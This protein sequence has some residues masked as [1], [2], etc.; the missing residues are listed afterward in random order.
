MADIDFDALLADS[1]TEIGR[2]PA[3]THGGGEDLR[4]SPEFETLETEFR[5]IETAGPAAVDWKML[6]RV[7]TELLRDRSKDLVLASRLVYG[8]QREEGY[9]GL[10]IGISIIGGLV[11]AHW[12]TMFPPLARE[13][14]RAGSF[15]WIAEKLA[16]VIEATPPAEDKRIFALI[17]H[18]R[19]VDLDMLLTEKMTRFP[20]A[21]GPLIRALRPHARDARQALEAGR[22]P[23]AEPFAAAAVPPSEAVPE[24]PAVSVAPQAASVEPVVPPLVAAP[25]ASTGPVVELVLGDDT[26]KAFEAL[27]NAALRLAATARQQLPSDAR[28]YHAARFALWS[29]LT[30]APPDKGG[31]TSLPPPQKARR[32]EIQALRTAGNHQGLLLSA[33]SAFASSPFWLDAQHIAFEAMTAL[34]SDYDQ[35][36]STIAGDL[37]ALLQKMPA[38]TGLCFNDGTPFAEAE[39]LQWIASDIRSGNG[40]EVEA[41]VDASLGSAVKLAQAGQT[42]AGLRL[43]M[44][45]S[46]TRHGGRERF[47][48]RL[49]MGEFCLRFELLAPLIALLESLVASAGQQTL[50]RWEPELAARLCGLEWR[51]VTHKN[52]KRFIDEKE[53]ILRKSRILGQLANLDI[54]MAAELSQP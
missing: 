47:V 44:H 43:L 42:L 32:A 28:A 31:K 18:D 15:D 7:T 10:A 19:L 6:N 24:P 3:G 39:T 27:S 20:A 8:L 21:L 16:P 38:L 23:P 53:I 48:A 1:R 14:G 35:A 5:K 12:E 54:V 36:K 51:T 41:A 50:D 45:H 30:A 26:Q 49:E 33:E 29:G 4:G 17:A 40:G 2:I 13:R 9:R 22:K 46:Q 25:V 37:A 34:G 52:A 11:E